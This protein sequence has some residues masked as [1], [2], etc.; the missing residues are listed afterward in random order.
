MISASDTGKIVLLT[1]KYNDTLL[2]CVVVCGWIQ[3][4]TT[5]M[6]CIFYFHTCKSYCSI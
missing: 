3:M 1:P 5:I 2:E 6:S 4:D